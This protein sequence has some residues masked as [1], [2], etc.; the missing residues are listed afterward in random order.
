M[1]FLLKLRISGDGEIV[2]FFWDRKDRQFDWIFVQ[3][4]AWNKIQGGG[5]VIKA[6]CFWW[7][8]DYAL[9]LDWKNCHFDWIFV[10]TVKYCS[11]VRILLLSKI[12]F[13]SPVVSHAG[14]FLYL[15]LLCTELKFGLLQR[16]AARGTKQT[17]SSYCTLN[18]F[19]KALLVDSSLTWCDDLFVKTWHR[20]FLKFWWHPVSGR[21]KEIIDFVK[22]IVA[23]T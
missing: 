17:L 20:I 7:Q 19:W 9:S 16:A 15:Y 8:R 23:E 13:F 18:A 5:I 6:I 11:L 14:V 10:A 12:T 3:T 4:F 22:S 21:F 1:W 2:Q